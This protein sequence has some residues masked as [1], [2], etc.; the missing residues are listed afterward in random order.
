MG[1]CGRGVLALFSMKLVTL[2]AE[3][4]FLT[5]TYIPTYLSIKRVQYIAHAMLCI[6]ASYS[7]PY[8]I[9]EVVA[10]SRLLLH[11]YAAMRKIH[12]CKF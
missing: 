4:P 7:T 12:A 10:Q 2:R 9:S 8:D 1:I 5:D 11:I 6:D 3:T